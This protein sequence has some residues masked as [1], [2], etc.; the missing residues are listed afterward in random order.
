VL[1]L[2][3]A[4]DLA[5]CDLAPPYKPPLILTSD[6]YRPAEGWV[7]GQPQSEIPQGDWWSVYANPTL[8]SLE[9]KVEANNPDLAASL[10]VLRQARELTV[11]AGYGLLPSLGLGAGVTQNRQSDHRPLRAPFQ[12]AEYGSKTIDVAA[13]WELDLW[14]SITNA[15]RAQRRNAQAAAADTSALKLSLQAELATDYVLLRGLDKETAIYAN[16][17]RYYQNGVEIT[18]LRLSHKIGSAL[19]V[20]QAENQLATTQASASGLEGKR[21]QLAHAIAVLIGEPATSFSLPSQADQPFTLPN[22]SPGVPST[23]LQRRPDIA[24]A[25]RRMAAANALIGVARAAFFPN[26]VLSAAGGFQ[27]TGLALVSLPN[28]FWSVGSAL[29][30]PLFEGGLRH[31]VL[32]G[33]AAFY[34]EQRDNYRSVVLNGF[35]EVEDQLSLEDSLAIQA[36][37]AE[38][39]ATA[40][41]GAEDLSLQLYRQGAADYLTVVIQEGAALSANLIGAQVA[42]DREQA[43]VNLVRALGGGWSTNDVPTERESE[44]P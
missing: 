33:S 18:Q 15:V 25:E 30:L 7:V 10:Q 39:A 1:L 17:I 32:A 3:F 5:A 21:E 14:E 35:R 13:Q 29:A 2:S 19:D 37:A 23:L 6:A 20:D 22:I 12:P 36:G 9:P 40:A 44:K 28:S 31:A 43:S 38:R 24:E 11:E 42:T 34:E 4:A 26:I 8:N 16:A 41:L 27:D